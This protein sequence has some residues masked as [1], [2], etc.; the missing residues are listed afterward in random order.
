MSTDLIN[1]NL[2]TSIHNISDDDLP[3][4]ITSQVKKLSEIAQKTN[5]AKIK[6]QEAQKKAEAAQKT[7]AGLLHRK[8]AI[9]KIQ[10]SGVSLSETVISLSDAQ[11]VYFEG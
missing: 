2:E 4:I 1:E 8:E 10:A 5:N 3:G 7:S 11:Q 6:A 9:E